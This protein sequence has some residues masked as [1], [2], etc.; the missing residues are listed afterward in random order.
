VAVASALGA[1]RLLSPPQG[2][3]VVPPGV[4]AGHQ[5]PGCLSSMPSQRRMPRRLRCLILLTP[6]A[7]Q[8]VS[9][10][11]V[12]QRW[13]LPA[14]SLVLPCRYVRSAWWRSCH[15]AS[16]A[17]LLLPDRALVSTGPPSPAALPS[18]VRSMQEGRAS[19]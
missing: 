18:A 12:G 15:R 4:V 17:L 14:P 2:V 1:L 16:P 9:A 7:P 5:P 3:A 10:P 11:G 19:A 13:G 8:E 6:R